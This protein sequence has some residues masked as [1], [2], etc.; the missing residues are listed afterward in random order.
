MTSYTITIFGVNVNDVTFD[1]TINDVTFWCNN[2]SKCKHWHKNQLYKHI[3]ISIFF[4]KAVNW[5]YI[6]I[7]TG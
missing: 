3:Y 2:N 5:K 7:N 6:N 1:V 4:Y